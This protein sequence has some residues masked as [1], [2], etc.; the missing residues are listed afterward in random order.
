MSEFNLSENRKQTFKANALTEGYH[1]SYNEE[2]VKEFIRRQI[3]RIDNRI[4]E[5]SEF[6]G[7]GEIML[8]KA[9]LNKVKRDMLEDAG[10]KLA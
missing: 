4:F 6:D 7:L 9:E 8:Q 5:L 10:E 3:E 2:D 1:Y